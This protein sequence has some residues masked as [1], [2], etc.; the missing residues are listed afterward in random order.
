MAAVKE[1]E[2]LSVPASLPGS[3]FSPSAP[4]HSPLT[5]TSSATDSGHSTHSRYN[6]NNNSNNNN[7]LSVLSRSL[8]VRSS[9][10]SSRR[11][12]TSI[13]SHVSIKSH[14]S[15]FQ[16]V[17]FD[18]DP[19]KD[20]SFWGGLALLISNMTG[21]GLVTLPI[22]AQSA[23]WL[24]TLVAFGVVS[25]LSSLSSL[26]ICEA[27]TQVPGNE[28]FQSNVEFNNLVECF[29]GRRYH[30]LVQ[31]ICFLA[32]QTTNIASIAVSA[33]LFDNLLIQIFHRTCGIQII[34]HAA[35]VCVTEQLASASPF[36]G[37]MMMT[38]G[39]LLAL[40]MILPLALLKLSENIWLQLASFILILLIV[41]Q[42]IVTFII[43]GLDTSLVP[44]IG[45]DISQTFGTILFNYAFITTIPSWANA[46]QPNVSIHKTV[47]WSVTITT[48]IY[49]LVAILGGMAYQIP[50]NSSLIQAISSSPDVTILSQITGYTFPIAALITSIPINIIVIRYNL[51]QSGACS[52]MWSNILAGVLPWLVAIPCMTGAGLT[53]VINWSSLFL[54]STANFIIPFILYIYSKRHRE[55]LDKLPIIEME[56][57]A[58]LS[59]EMSR[60]SFS[61]HSRRN[62]SV[63][64]SI[65]RRLTGSS[66]QNGPQPHLD[67]AMGPTTGIAAATIIPLSMGIGSGG[68]IHHS[69]S[70]ENLN[71]ESTRHGSRR[72]YH[73]H[74]N[75]G[76]GSSSVS[77]FG[78]VHKRAVEKQTKMIQAEQSVKPVPPM[79]L[80]SQSTAPE[81][82]DDDQS[83]SIDLGLYSQEKES[84][85]SEKHSEKDLTGE[86]KDISEANSNLSAALKKL[87]RKSSIITTHQQ[88]TSRSTLTLP[89]LSPPVRLSPPMAEIRS[90][91][92]PTIQH[93][94]KYEQRT[95]EPSP[96]LSPP[97]SPAS[98]HSALI[99]SPSSS[100]GRSSPRGSHEAS[101]L[102]STASPG[103]GSNRDS[104]KPDATLTD[105]SRLSPGAGSTSSSGGLASAFNFQLHHSPSPSTPD[106][107]GSVHS[108]DRRVSF[109][110]ESRAVISPTELE[111]EA[112]FGDESRR[113]GRT[114]AS[115]LSSGLG[116]SGTSLGASPGSRDVRVLSH[117]WRVPLLENHEE[118]DEDEREDETDL[119]DET[120]GPE[121][122]LAKTEQSHTPSSGSASGSG[123]DSDGQRSEAR[124]GSLGRMAAAF[125]AQPGAFS[126]MTAPV[127]S[128]LAPEKAGKERDAKSVQ[129]PTLTF[130]AQD[131][132]DR[133]Q[134]LEPTQG[135]PKH[136][137][138]APSL[139]PSGPPTFL[140]GQTVGK[141]SHG[142][143]VSAS[144]EILDRSPRSQR[145][146]LRTQS[147][148]SLKEI[149]QQDRLAP[150]ES[151]NSMS[152]RLTP[153]SPSLLPNARFEATTPHSDEARDSVTPLASP[154]AQ[155]S[156][157]P[158][159]PLH[160]RNS[161]NGRNNHRHSV[162]A[163]FQGGNNYSI[164]GFNPHPQTSAQHPPSPGSNS[165][166]DQAPTSAQGLGSSW[167]SRRHHSRDPSRSTMI[168][169][170][171][172]YSAGS[173]PPSPLPTPS[174]L[175][176]GG[177][178]SVGM[179]AGAASAAGKRSEEQYF[180]DSTTIGSLTI[181]AHHTT[182]T[183]TTSTGTAVADAAG[184]AEFERAEGCL[185]ESNFHL[186]LYSI[187][188]DAQWSLRAIPDWFPLSNTK[189]AWTSLTIL[190]LA[191][192]STIVYDFIQLARGNDLVGGS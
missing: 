96:T 168:S 78:E 128:S 22:V 102:R 13:K 36:S 39:V 90:D 155:P 67:L 148:Q 21:P 134:G 149:Q 52:Y 142:R 72:R 26:F 108:L 166:F 57:Q 151:A 187:G 143:T 121:L 117:D 125:V 76:F 179:G 2:R 159:T 154:A 16:N 158:R 20:I 88:P 32:M 44:V 18:P 184:V 133:S 147:T 140:P 35:F 25:L 176:T 33:Q 9:I 169:F 111:R 70:D 181:A 170:G 186:P 123:S 85:E 114:L 84:Y 62:V 119:R 180:P 160:H 45:N 46:K 38:A 152:I 112:S 59:R 42:W 100:P 135:R 163:P 173:V 103:F 191:I 4:S 146:T 75:V 189:V 64:G 55:K 177:G 61:G 157:Q 141:R 29:F 165:A 145:P 93:L 31:I 12:A 7:R 68:I 80:L 77:D 71:G 175:T 185:H 1:L 139:S 101:A 50:N 137:V 23:G 53:T 83:S 109:S 144:A 182:V 138:S 3:G 183:A 48:I 136:S 19:I 153:P 99:R 69:V 126:I 91:S 97:R 34:P 95:L 129:V 49:I 120:L 14:I 54:V 124:R 30:L 132:I 73:S 63:S 130:T 6:S 106:S 105:T 104:L 174:E 87:N 74:Q 82:E 98:P 164:P 8:S 47:G 10:A 188:F 66:M 28:H 41:T 113:S 150:P 107:S 17:R 162:A 116:R 37:V 127:G 24:P 122:Y 65:R 172:P 110:D 156:P 79:I 40:S 131:T 11:S 118:V 94:E 167:F 178:L 190:V 161:F 115:T 5:A 56:Q 86:A 51:I 58:R 92:R 81:P 27:M 171:M 15:T 192:G 43:H 60:S 89:P